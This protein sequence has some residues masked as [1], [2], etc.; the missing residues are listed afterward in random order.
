MPDTLNNT[1]KTRIQIK[2]DTEK[3]WNT[4][5]SSRGF[6]PLKGEMIIYSPDT[7]HNYSRLKIGDGSTDVVSLPFIDAG[8][9]DG[10]SSFILK[11]N[12]ASQFP[13]PGSSDKLYVD[14]SKN[15]IYH[16]I[17]T[18]GYVQLGMG[19]TK[20]IKTVGY[21]GAGK[22]TGASIEDSIL[23]IDLGVAPQLLEE[24]VTVFTVPNEE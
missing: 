23:K 1:L 21:F 18:Q 12:T 4:L 5:Q 11:Y 17:G 20:M 9:L 14:L 16:Y 24:R 19:K 7:N 15:T 22:P 8:T 13:Q 6:I 3:N 10:E 2:N